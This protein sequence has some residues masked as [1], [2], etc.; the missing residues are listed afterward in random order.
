[1]PEAHKHA[2][3]DG[4]ILLEIIFSAKKII[5]QIG[6]LEQKLQHFILMAD[7]EIVGVCRRSRFLP[8]PYTLP[9]GNA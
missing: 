4:E 3:D 5:V 2:D 9:V 7:S 8:Y 6:Q 1:M